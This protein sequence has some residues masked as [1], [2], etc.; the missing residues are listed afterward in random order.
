MSYRCNNNSCSSGEDYGY[1]GSGLKWA[2]TMNCEGFS[3]DD[4]EWKVIIS[5]GK[6]TVEYTKENS[7]RD[8]SGQHGVKYDNERRKAQVHHPSNPRQKTPKNMK[9]DFV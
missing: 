3:M 5:L 9:S 7:I 2:V 4:D 8:D 6:K 1:I